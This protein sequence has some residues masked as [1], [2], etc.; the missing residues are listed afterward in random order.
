MT[1]HVGKKTVTQTGDA[2]TV[3]VGGASQGL[4][5]RVKDLNKVDVLLQVNLTLDPV[6]DSSL[7]TN[8]D[9]SDNVVGMTIVFAAGTTVTPEVT[10]LGS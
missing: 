7:P 6:V 9:I 4:T 8:V 5:V 1:V 2:V 10:V 3:A